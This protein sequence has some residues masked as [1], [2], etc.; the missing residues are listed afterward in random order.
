MCLNH[1]TLSRDIVFGGSFPNVQDQKDADLFF[2]GDNCCK[3]EKHNFKMSA[4]ATLLLHKNNQQNGHFFGN[5]VVLAVLAMEKWKIPE[6]GCPGVECA[7][8]LRRLQSA[9]LPQE[10]SSCSRD[11]G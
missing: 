1:F 5:L 4:Q 9:V 8:E 7:S 6:C 2:L 10:G 3:E 11:L